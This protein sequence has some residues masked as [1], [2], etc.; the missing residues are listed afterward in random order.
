V[1]R[2]SNNDGPDVLTHRGD[3]CLDACTGN[4]RTLQQWSNECAASIRGNPT[5]TH[6]TGSPIALD[7]ALEIGG[8][9]IPTP[10]HIRMAEP[11]DHAVIEVI[12]NAADAI[13]IDLLKPEHW[14]PAPSGTVRNAQPGFL[15]VALESVHD[16][17]IGFVHVLEIEGVAHLEQLSVLPTHG[18]RG[19]G[20]KLV[21]ASMAEASDRGYDELT[22]RTYA[23]V[24]WNAPFY[25]TCGFTESEPA[26]DF[27]RR[28]VS[29]EEEFGLDRYGRRLQM[30]V[31][32]A[33]RRD[34]A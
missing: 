25:E 17:V 33:L 23:G 4:S 18:R 12:E 14:E 11:G 7:E 20:R 30:T 21:E 34:L 5:H 9:E 15:L 32:L 3:L 16:S 31:Q 19:N 13:L 26:T 27:Q 6:G 1:L 28:L 22:L 2:V 10:I 29:L 8:P 24:P